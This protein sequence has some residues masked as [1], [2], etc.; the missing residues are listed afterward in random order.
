[1]YDI[2]IRYNTLCNDDRLYWRAIIN[3]VEYVAENII[4]N[5]PM[6]TTRDIVFDPNRNEMVDKHHISCTTDIISWDND[7]LIIG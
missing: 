7:T 2:K 3:G 5:I 1:M 4:I 6:K